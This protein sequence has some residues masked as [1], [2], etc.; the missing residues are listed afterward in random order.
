MMGDVVIGQVSGWS[1]KTWRD[2]MSPR[3]LTEM[4]IMRFDQN[5][6]RWGIAAE[7]DQREACSKGRSGFLV[8]S[9]LWS[10]RTSDVAWI[11]PV[12][13]WC[14]SED[15]VPTLLWKHLRLAVL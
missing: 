10:W 1:R 4:L 3:V 15:G 6:H 12:S 13:R 5:P 2:R 9:I 7:H 8:I 14:R 11:L